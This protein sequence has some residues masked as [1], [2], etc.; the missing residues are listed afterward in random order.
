MCLV[1]NMSYTIYVMGPCI[2]QIDYCDHVIS[3]LILGY[4]FRVFYMKYT[5]VLYYI[6][7]RNYPT[8][9]IYI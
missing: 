2:F 6:S 9:L 8:F 5:I 1:A 7:I 4:S 3:Y